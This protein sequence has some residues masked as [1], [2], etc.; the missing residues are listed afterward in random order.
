M[1]AM[2]ISTNNVNSYSYSNVGYF[3]FKYINI[4]RLLT[5]S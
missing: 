3:K 4:F 1:Y 2:N 5:I